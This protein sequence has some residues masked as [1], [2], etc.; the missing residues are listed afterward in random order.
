MIAG[1]SE[2][3]AQEESANGASEAVGE[4]A[5]EE[6]TTP[7]ESDVD[8]VDAER[9]A[10][11]MIEI[12]T[13]KGNFHVWTRKIGDHPTIK[14]LVLHGGPG[15]T[16]EYLKNIDNY[17]PG[18]GIEYYYYD[19][20][21]SYF[22]DQPDDPSLWTIERFVDEVEQ[23]RTAL[24]LGP[25]N[26]YLY[27]QSWGGAL[28]MEYALKHQENLKGL[29]ISNMMASG[30]AYGAYT[31]DV[32]MPQMDPEALAEIKALEAA[33]DYGNPRYE[34][35]LMTHHYV[36]HVL[37]LPPEEWPLD[38]IHGF[39]HLNPNIYI[40][41]QGPSELGISGV[42]GAW[43]ISDQIHAITVP[44]LVIGAT[45]DTMSPAYMAWMAEEIPNARFLL[46][47]NGS[48]LA[49]VDDAEIYFAGLIKFIQDVDS[50]AFQASE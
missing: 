33:E 30:P 46:C 21:G 3:V 39:E 29:I 8:P 34:E 14:V 41:M 35:L 11:Q 28:A 17:F 16:H 12:E 18:A 22:S 37:R 5:L 49:L 9:A 13:P 19:Q 27:G 48:H 6:T 43:D 32:L 31:T 40:P 15:A 23:V 38:V 42:L 44:T 25:D 2:K 50:D 47:L 7:P 24:G 36:D 20:L 26:F 10:G 45:Y 1:C 4:A